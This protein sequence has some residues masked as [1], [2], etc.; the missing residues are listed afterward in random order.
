[1]KVDKDQLLAIVK[2]AMIRQEVSLQ[3]P[4]N[5]FFKPTRAFEEWV[6]TLPDDVEVVDCGCGLGKLAKFFSP[7]HVINIDLHTRDNEEPG[8]CHM[9][10]SLYPFDRG[11]IVF[12]ARP[13]VGEWIDDTAYMALSRGA[14]VF[15]ATAKDFIVENWKRET[16]ALNV[17]EAG[18]TLWELTGD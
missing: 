5:T 14:R 12:F 18:E 10:A 7:R 3:F 2:R 8:I 13:C 17:G 11:Q 6:A 9:D 4:D 16:V 15:V 1:M